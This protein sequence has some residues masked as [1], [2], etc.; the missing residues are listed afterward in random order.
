MLTLITVLYHHGLSA[1][2]GHYTLD[3]CHAGKT[4]EAW[5]RGWKEEWIRI[6][7][8]FVSDLQPRDVFD[9]STESDDR[10]AYLLFYRQ[11]VTSTRV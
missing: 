1:T 7:D 4:R 5:N 6:D 8:E 11:I 3:I 10:V 9:I 2:G